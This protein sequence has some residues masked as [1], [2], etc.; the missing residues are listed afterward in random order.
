MSLE[1][2]RLRYGRYSLWYSD[3]LLYLSDGEKTATINL[4]DTS[5]I[6]WTPDTP[7]SYPAIPGGYKPN[8][9]M[10]LLVEIT[11]ALNK[12]LNIDNAQEWFD[13]HK[14]QFTG[15]SAF[16]FWQS[17]NYPDIMPDN[18]EKRY[19]QRWTE[20]INS[21]SSTKFDYE[22]YDIWYAK[23]GYEPNVSQEKI[24]T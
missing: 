15:Y 7:G 14:E 17:L 5:L 1:S 20:Y 10:G 9:L 4:A 22:L 21:L 2:Q 24:I 19:K 13:A 3:N 6:E 23:K 18:M 12:G 16:E 11:E 8:T